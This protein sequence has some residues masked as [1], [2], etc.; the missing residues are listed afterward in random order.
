MSA[1]CLISQQVRYTS[2]RRGCAGSK[3]R[4]AVVN[5]RNVARIEEKEAS[6]H[7]TTTKRTSLA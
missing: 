4:R 1:R 2:R 6:F 7:D 5:G 3:E